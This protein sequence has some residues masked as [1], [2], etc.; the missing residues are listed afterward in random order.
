VVDL[1]LLQ[2]VML[3]MVLRQLVLMVVIGIRLLLLPRDRGG[4]CRHSGEL[5]FG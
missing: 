3:L 1:E 4:G 5:R 2:A